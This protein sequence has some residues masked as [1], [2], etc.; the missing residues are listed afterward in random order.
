MPYLQAT[1]YSGLPSPPTSQNL[2]CLVA[3]ACPRHSLPPTVRPTYLFAPVPRCSFR[4]FCLPTYLGTKVST[5]ATGYRLQATGYRP[6]APAYRRLPTLPLPAYEPTHLPPAT[7]SQ[8]PASTT[9]PSSQPAKLPYFL[10]LNPRLSRVSHTQPPP[11][12]EFLDSSHGTK[13]RQL[14]NIPV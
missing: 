14:T 2:P 12:L 11:H 4:H 8:Q 6:Q 7:S 3:T 5:K 10:I 9:H 13:A 1:S